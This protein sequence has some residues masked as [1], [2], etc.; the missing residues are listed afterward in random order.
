VELYIHSPKCVHD[1]DRDDV[2]LVLD[3]PVRRDV[4][5][6]PGHVVVFGPNIASREGVNVAQFRRRGTTATYRH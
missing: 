1:M 6:S 2:V 4:A 5:V 3:P